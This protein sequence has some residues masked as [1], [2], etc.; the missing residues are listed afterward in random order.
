LLLTGLPAHTVCMY[1][2]RMQRRENKPIPT[3]E[4][5]IPA[6]DAYSQ[7]RVVKKLSATQ[8]GAR[9]LARLYGDAL[10]C[11]RY[12]H[13][14]ER[15]CR[16][17]TVELVVDRAPIARRNRSLDAIVVVRIPF[18]DTERQ[19]QAQVHGARWDAKTKVWYMRRSTAKQLGL[20]K[21]IIETLPGLE[22]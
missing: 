10:V 19:M 6:H 1:S 3:R 13:D 9:K 4:R 18:G 7:T 20:Q 12:R 15:R 21:L 16:Y 14:A 5:S 22:R 8:A 17:T 11:V 2:L